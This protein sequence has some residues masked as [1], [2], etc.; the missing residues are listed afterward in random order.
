MAP[1]KSTTS[2]TSARWWKPCEAAMKNR[3]WRLTTRLAL[4]TLLGRWCWKK[5]LWINF[6]TC[7][8][9]KSSSTVIMKPTI[10]RAFVRMTDA[11]LQSPKLNP[12]QP[13][14]RPSWWI[15]VKRWRQRNL[16]RYPMCSD[17]R[18][19][20]VRGHAYFNLLSLS[21]FVAVFDV[22]LSFS[23]KTLRHEMQVNSQVSM[24]LNDGGDVAYVRAGGE[25]V[26]LLHG[27]ELCS[28]GSGSWHDGADAVE[29]MES[30]GQWIKCQV[31]LDTPV[32]LDRKRVLQ[33]LSDLPCLEKAVGLSEL[34][35]LLEDRGEAWHDCSRH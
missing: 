7:L 33:H 22:I 10:L 32:I 12:S 21:F 24:I 17:L 26:T 2:L 11:Q 20:T 14:T 5:V 34:L 9:W 29:V 25:A 23:V 19:L 4:C 27:R 18:P 8:D 16:L 13:P 3:L 30:Q 35:H 15:A 6:R 1:C 28:F 31:T